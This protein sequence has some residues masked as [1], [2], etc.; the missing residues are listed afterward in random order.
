LKTGKY[1]KKAVKAAAEISDIVV[2]LADDVTDVLKAA[3]RAVDG[4]DVVSK[5]KTIEEVME[6]VSKYQ[7][8]SKTTNLLDELAN[9]GVKYNPDD[10][11]TVVKNSDGNLMWLE[12]GNSK[13]GLQ[14]IMERHADDFAAQG[15]NDIP[16]LL[17]DVLST[18]PIKTGIFCIFFYTFKYW[19]HSELYFIV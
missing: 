6:Q 14:H 13:A 9:S 19:I 7:G 16:G 5:G 17:E 1:S 8:G 12:N 15:V 4:K 10:V 3:D 18:N 2:E 11:V